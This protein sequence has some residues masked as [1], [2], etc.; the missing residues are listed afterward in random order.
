MKLFVG[1]GA[2]GHYLLIYRNGTDEHT[3][4]HVALKQQKMNILK[5]N[6]GIIASSVR[7]TDTIQNK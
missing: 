7:H 2:N 6:L 4:T 1:I 3:H 5:K